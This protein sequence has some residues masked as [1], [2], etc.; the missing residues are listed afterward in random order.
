MCTHARA[1]TVGFYKTIDFNF[2]VIVHVINLRGSE[3][4]STDTARESGNE[5]TKIQRAMT[6][7]SFQAWGDMQPTDLCLIRQAP[8]I[9]RHCC[10][11]TLTEHTLNRKA[12]LNMN[13]N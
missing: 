7:G 1:T 5:Y 13:T 2:L 3:S 10:M 8:F 9:S 6:K 12:K 4:G 11:S